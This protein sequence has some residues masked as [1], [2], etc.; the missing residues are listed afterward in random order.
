MSVCGL[1]IATCNGVTPS[2]D[3]HGSVRRRGMFEQPYGDQTLPRAPEG[4]SLK[5]SLQNE[6]LSTKH[7]K[8]H[9]MY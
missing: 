5:C 1:L 9:H 4:K 7:F 3:T 2:C 6:G 8:K